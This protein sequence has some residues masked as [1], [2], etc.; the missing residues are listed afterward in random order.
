MAQKINPVYYNI[1]SELDITNSSFTYGE[2][3]SD[4]VINVIINLYDEDIAFED[5]YF[6][7]IGCGCGKLLLDITKKLNIYSCGIE[8]EPKRYEECKQ[9]IENYKMDTKIELYNDNFK[10]KYFGNYDV[11]YCCNF[12]F[13]KEDN[14]MLYKKIINEFTG[15]VL[16]FDYNHILKPFYISEDIVKTSW[17]P[18]VKIFIFKL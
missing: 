12:V 11:L 7:D 8:I 17:S 4:N 9:Q 18:C 15:Y 14:L 6:I 10:N 1:S 16:L 5:Y 2:V 3:Y 13:S